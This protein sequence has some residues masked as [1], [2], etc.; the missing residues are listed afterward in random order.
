MDFNAPN[1]RWPW[2]TGKMACAEEPHTKSRERLNSIP[3]YTLPTIRS[4]RAEGGRR[5]VTARELARMKRAREAGE[6]GYFKW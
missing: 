3:A 1:A 2:E 5:P 4:R 6:D